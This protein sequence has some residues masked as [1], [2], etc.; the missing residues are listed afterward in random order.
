[1]FMYTVTV[2][3]LSDGFG[4]IENFAKSVVPFVPNFFLWEFWVR[5]GP[6]QSMLVIDVP[7]GQALRV[8]VSS[9]HKGVDH[10]SQY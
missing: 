10:C 2:S 7:S 4:D 9:C 8:C 3:I 5:V 1:M 6:Q